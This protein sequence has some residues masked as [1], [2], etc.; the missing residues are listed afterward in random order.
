MDRLELWDLITETMM[1]NVAQMRAD[2]ERAAN[3][4]ESHPPHHGH[5]KAWRKV[6]LREE[7]MGP[8]YEAAIRSRER[9]RPELA[10]RLTLPEL[11][12]SG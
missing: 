3:L 10:V 7:T 8:L 9:E 11:T 12:N 4:A 2:S 1:G 6:M 5:Q